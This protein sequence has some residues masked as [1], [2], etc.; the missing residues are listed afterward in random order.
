MTSL[1]KHPTNPKKSFFRTA[2]AYIIAYLLFAIVLLSL[3]LLLF[4]IRSDVIMVAFEL[5]NNRAVVRG[6]SNISVV[7]AG[8][9]ML[10]GVVYSDDYLRRGIEAGKMWKHI[11]RIFIV[12]AAAWALWMLAYFIA[13]WI[14]Y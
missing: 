12:T 8:I 11:L 7:I 1:D 6:L 10:V 14:I 5:G 9:V 4:R 3:V 2:G 13:I